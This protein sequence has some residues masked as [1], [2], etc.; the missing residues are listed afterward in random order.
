MDKF[1]GFLPENTRQYFQQMTA[2]MQ[3]GFRQASQMGLQQYQQVRGMM[4]TNPFLNTGNMFGNVMDAY[5][6]WRNMFTNAVAPVVRI[7]TPN[8]QTKAIQEWADIANRMMVFNIKNAELQYKIYNQGTK[9][10]DQLAE[11]IMDKIGKGEE[12]KSMMTLYQEWMNISDKAYVSLFESD[13]YSQ[14]MAE[15][16]ALQMR[17]RRDMEQQMEGMLSGVPVATRSEMDELYRTIYD[18]KKQVRQLE[19]MMELGA[20][21]NPA[22]SADTKP[23]ATPNNNTINPNNS[24]NNKAKKA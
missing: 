24:G 2:Q 19:K 6:H 18:L 15:V 9:V 11:N 3:E 13:E 23:S 16:S 17:L 20:E 22:Q 4:G 7:M 8:Q 5:T 21:E 10:M 12:V 1:F 14:L